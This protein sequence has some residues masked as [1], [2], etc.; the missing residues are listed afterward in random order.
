MTSALPSTWCCIKVHT[1]DQGEMHKAYAYTKHT[2]TER[3]Y[4]RMQTF[5]M[6]PEKVKV[7]HSDS[8][9][10]PPAASSSHT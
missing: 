1:K 7:R 6:Y 10:S 9:G 3:V 4:A 5:N 8:D 2:R